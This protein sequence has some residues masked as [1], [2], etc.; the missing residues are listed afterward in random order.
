MMKEHAFAR[1]PFK[2]PSRLPAE[3]PWP[4]LQNPT[5]SRR[6][7]RRARI[8]TWNGKD[9]PPEFRTLPVGRYIVQAVEDDAPTLTPREETGIETALSPRA[10]KVTYTEEAVADIVQAITYLNDRNPTRRR[11]P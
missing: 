3:T 6:M 5:R 10:L 1:V 4:L 9:L 11:E 7:G 8:V 2:P